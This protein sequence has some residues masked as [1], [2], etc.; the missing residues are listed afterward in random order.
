M[1]RQKLPDRRTEKIK[2]CLLLFPCFLLLPIVDV[3][4]AIQTFGGRPA[5]AVLDTKGL[6]TTAILTWLF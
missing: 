2:N 4:G 1:Y 5:C 6:L 3:V